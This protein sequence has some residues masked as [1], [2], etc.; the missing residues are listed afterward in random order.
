MTHNLIQISQDN[1][2][3]V[4]RQFTKHCTIIILC[5][6]RVYE[7]FL[8]E[9]NLI[10]LVARYYNDFVHAH[11][12]SQSVTDQLTPLYTPNVR[13]FIHLFFREPDEHPRHPIGR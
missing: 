9:I 12:Y 3:F 8:L 4:S 1:L 7:K 6:N 13:V 5:H 11:F 10:E 2:S